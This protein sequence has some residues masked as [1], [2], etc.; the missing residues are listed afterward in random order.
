MT[1]IIR[2]VEKSLEYQWEGWLAI[3]GLND[4]EAC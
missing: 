4:T 3:E 1:L 2:L